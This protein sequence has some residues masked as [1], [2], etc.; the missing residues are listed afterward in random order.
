MSAVVAA[1]NDGVTARRAIAERTGLDAEMVDAVLDR[2]TQMGA[3]TAEPLGGACASGGCGTCGA[4]S[5]CAG[6]P[7]AGAPARR[8]PVLLTLRRRPPA[9]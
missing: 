1:M 8:G 5:V 7:S 3:V 9:A 2:L 6:A 4:A